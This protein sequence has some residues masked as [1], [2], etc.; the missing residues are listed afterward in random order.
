[1]VAAFSQKGLPKPSEIQVLS[2]WIGRSPELNSILRFA[3]PSSSNGISGNLR[4][5]ERARSTSRQWFAGGWIHPRRFTPNLSTK[6]IP[7]KI[8]RLKLK[9]SGEFPMD[10]GIPPHKLKIMLESSP[11]KSRVLVRRLAIDARLLPRIYL[12][13][14]TCMYVCIYIYIYIYE[15]K[16]THIHF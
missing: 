6:I 12:Y 5:G 8:P 1:M 10:L 2:S 14:Y 4:S 13:V 7:T 3:K 15:Y 9:L 11:P 16:Y